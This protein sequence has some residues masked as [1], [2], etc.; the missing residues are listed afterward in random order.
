MK[1]FISAYRSDS[2]LK[3]ISRLYNGLQDIKQKYHLT[4]MGKGNYERYP[5]GSLATIL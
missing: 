1:I 3:V 5:R 4:E 2:G